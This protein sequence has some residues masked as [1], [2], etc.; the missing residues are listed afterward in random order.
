MPAVTK[1]GPSRWLQSVLCV[2]HITENMSRVILL[3]WDRELLPKKDQDSEF[4]KGLLFS[5]QQIQCF[6]EMVLHNP[7]TVL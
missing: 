3:N 2:V 7:Q 1:W 4:L 5:K 6:D